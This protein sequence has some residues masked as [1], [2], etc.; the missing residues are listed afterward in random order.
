MKPQC[1]YCFGETIEVVSDKGV[2]RYCHDCDKFV[3]EP[4]EPEER[5]DLSYKHD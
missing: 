4:D 2:H 3:V 5:N 1:P